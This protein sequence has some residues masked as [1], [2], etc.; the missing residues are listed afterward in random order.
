MLT[1]WYIISIMEIMLIYILYIFCF[2][3]VWGIF[4]LTGEQNSGEF[5][6][7]LNQITNFY[8]QNISP[9]MKM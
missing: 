5:L 8:A 3:L 9:H 2:A 6:L 4:R 7:N 1:Q